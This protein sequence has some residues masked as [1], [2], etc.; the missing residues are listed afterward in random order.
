M[1]QAAI[2]LAIA[3]VLC[4][5]SQAAI[6]AATVWQSWSTG[7]IHNGGGF[8]DA[9]PGTSVDYSQQD[10]AQLTLTDLACTSGSTTLTSATGGFTQAM[11][12]NT[13]KIA[14]GT[15]AAVDWY[16]IPMGGYVSSNQVT[17]DRT[18]ASGGDMSSATGRLGGAI[19][20]GNTAVDNEF[21]NRLANG[22]TVYRRGDWTLSESV[23]ASGRD[24]VAT[25]PITV[26]GCDSSGGTTPTGGDRPA[27]TDGAA[28]LFFY[29][30][31]YWHVRNFEFTGSSTAVLSCGSN[32]GNIIENCGIVNDSATAGRDALV[33]GINCTVVNCELVSTAGEA[34][35]Q[36]GASGRFV[37][38]HIHDSVTGIDFTNTA[39][40]TVLNSLIADCTTGIL[41]G[42]G[43]NPVIAGCTIR[44]C[45]TGYS[46]TTFG[47]LLVN[48]IIAGSSTAEI[49]MGT[50]Y[51]GYIGY[52]CWG[53][54]SP[55]LTN[56]TLALRGGNLS[57]DPLLTDPD[58]G[59]YTLGTSSPC[60]DAGVQVG[61]T[62]GVVGDYK[63]NIGADQ[64]DGVSA[65]SGVI[66]GP[67]PQFIQ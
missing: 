62:E 33:T 4:S 8:Y 25:A 30:G 63:V 53:E 22:N 6:N 3:L 27:C 45:A 50:D 24:A 64:D 47:V 40:L 1:R 19:Q 31:D 2:I 67:K 10:T 51:L 12:G 13:I 61:T 48:N 57:S 14:S 34:V 54:A 39:N 49:A 21:W 41:L 23:N 55:T 28:D 65:S 35:F 56:C 18:C 20:L 26:I 32:Y 38:C 52:N 15:N 60:L 37:G 11:E 7:H 66:M 36:G 5:A 9:T 17:I 44:G 16:Q 29:V 58:N 59:D 43:A 42:T 46:G